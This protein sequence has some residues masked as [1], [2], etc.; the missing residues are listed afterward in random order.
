[1]NCNRLRLDSKDGLRQSYRRL[2]QYTALSSPAYICVAAD[3]PILRA[4]Q[5]H[6]ELQVCAI[7]SL[8]HSTAYQELAARVRNFA[9]D[10]L[11]KFFHVLVIPS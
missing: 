6:R 8:A 9:V 2:R 5:L 11:G 3:D 10:M 4:F 7:N 1:M